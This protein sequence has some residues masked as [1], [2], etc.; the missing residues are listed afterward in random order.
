MGVCLEDKSPHMCAAR[1]GVCGLPP[2]VVARDRDK[3][4]ESQGHYQGTIILH[5]GGGGKLIVLVFGN[6]EDVVLEG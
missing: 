3:G 6:G 2:A 5:Q 4:A 1:S